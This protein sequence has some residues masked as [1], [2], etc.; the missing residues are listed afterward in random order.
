MEFIGYCIRL[1]AGLWLA[2]DR[3]RHRRVVDRIR[4]P[5][6]RRRWNDLGRTDYF[7]RIFHSFET[8]VGLFARQYLSDDVTCWH[9][10]AAMTVQADDHRDNQQND[11]RDGHGDSCHQDGAGCGCISISTLSGTGR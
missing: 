2:V 9:H 6:F 1:R 7:S 11:Y 10:A 3:P 5:F 8:A 4:E